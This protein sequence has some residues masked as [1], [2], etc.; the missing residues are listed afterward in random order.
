MRLLPW[1]LVLAFVPT[2]ASSEPKTV[3]RAESLILLAPPMLENGREVLQDLG[4][5]TKASTRTAYA[6]VVPAA[7]SYPRM[8]VY[9]EQAAPLNYWKFGSS[10]DADWTK[11]RFRS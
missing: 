5:N 11:A 4:W 1:L 7:G 9:L 10:L 8:Q 2:V 3:S 6:A